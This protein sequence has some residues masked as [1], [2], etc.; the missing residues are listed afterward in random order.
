MFIYKIISQYYSI[1][2]MYVHSLG[3]WGE[4]TKC[5]NST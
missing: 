5:L 2:C 3:K 1:V 4:V